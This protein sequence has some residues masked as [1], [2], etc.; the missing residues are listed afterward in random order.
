MSN[1]PN[2]TKPFQ[3]KFTALC[4]VA[5]FKITLKNI[6]STVAKIIP[7]MAGLIPPSTA[8]TP[9][10]FSNFVSRVATNKMMINDGNTTPSVASIAPQ[11]PP[12]DEPTNVAIFTAIGPGVDSATAIKFKSS[13][14][15]SQPYPKQSSRISEIIP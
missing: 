3:S 11:N 14:S 8:F 4:M 5:I 13:S 1:T 2:I 15:V 9:A 7:T 6:V 10:Y 12:C